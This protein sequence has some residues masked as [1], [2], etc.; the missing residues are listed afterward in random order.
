MN[1]ENKYEYYKEIF[2]K[3]IETNNNLKIFLKNLSLYTNET[4]YIYGSILRSDYNSKSDTDICIF[5]NN[6]NFIKKKLQNYLEVH[7]KKF[8]TTYWLLPKT[9]RLA[10]GYKIFYKNKEKNIQVEISLYD[11]KYKEEI[12]DEHYSKTIL[13][14]YATILLYIIKFLHYNLEILNKNTYSEYKKI[15]LSTGIGRKRDDYFVL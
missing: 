2:N 8:K 11:I 13:P 1:Y 3:N 15:I 5:S 12:L 10:T 14:Y 4:I 9:K 7:E 6:I